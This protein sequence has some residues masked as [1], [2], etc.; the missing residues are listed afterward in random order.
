MP[1]VP[2][3]LRGALRARRW[4]GR[5]AAVAALVEVVALAMAA[6]LGSGLEVVRVVV[7]GL[8]EVVDLEGALVVVLAM[9]AALE[10][11]LVVGK[12]AA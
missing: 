2:L 1:L 8:G 6:V 5:Q 10:A 7:L 4:T 3:L 9:E 11:G 12:V